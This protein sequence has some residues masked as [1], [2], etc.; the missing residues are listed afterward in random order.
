MLRQLR[1][2][3]GHSWETEDDTAAYCPRCGELADNVSLFDEAPPPPEIPQDRLDVPTRDA[4]GYPVIPGYDLREKLPPGPLGVE[5]YRAR[6]LVAE[7]PVVVEVVVARDDSGQTAWAALRGEA[8][9][10]G[11]LDHPNVAPLLA[12]GERERLLFYNILTDDSGPTLAEWLG[13]KPL[14]WRE[15]VDLGRVLALALQHAHE[16]GVV[17]RAIQPRFIRLCPAE[18]DGPGCVRLRGVWY[19]PRLEK[20]GQARTKVIE[21]EPTDLEAQPEIPAYLSPEQ[22][23]GQARDIGPKTDQFALGLV[24]AELLLG[25][26]PLAGPNRMQTLDNAM[27]SF[28]I[29]EPLRSRVSADLYAVLVKATSYRA[30]D[31]YDSLGELAGDLEDVR[32]GRAPA[33]RPPGLLRLLRGAIPVGLLLAF[34]LGGGLAGVVLLLG[35]LAPDPRFGPSGELAQLR[36]EANHAQFREAEREKA[37]YEQLSRF[38]EPV[39]RARS[40]RLFDAGGG[41]VAHEARNQ[42]QAARGWTRVFLWRRLDG[43]EAQRLTLPPAARPTA[44][45]WEIPERG[46]LVGCTLREAGQVHC[47]QGEPLQ[48]QLIDRFPWPVRALT[49]TGVE[50]ELLILTS[51]SAENRSQLYRLGG[52]PASDLQTPARTGLAVAQSQAGPRVVTTDHKSGTWEAVG[53]LARMQACDHP[54]AYVVAS[55]R[56]P[57]YFVADNAAQT[58]FFTGTGFH[59][60]VALGD[61]PLVTALVRSLSGKWLAAGGSAG[62]VRLWAFEHFPPVP[63]TLALHDRWR[64]GQRPI[65]ALAFLPGEECLAIGTDDGHLVLYDLPTGLELVNT[66]LGDG[67]ITALAF[68]PTGRKLAVIHGER[69]LLWE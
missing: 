60:G 6:Q 36:R 30:G 3:S 1:C 25:K 43:K 22:A 26:P 12:V 16:R 4:R 57:G 63:P 39:T 11:K 61:L 32:V 48:R 18:G 20:F 8:R 24:V 23:L 27:R 17:H 54:T 55:P 52:V 45:N 62:V 35:V 33:A 44:L 5:R 49:W 10:L 14:P 41:E 13:E 51:S 59:L 56:E 9:A 46:L 64:P 69:V 42:M 15:A 19:R 40:Q 31:R 29:L 21:H 28:P 34:L 58:I 37:H 2:L 50:Q 67:A 53:R 65:T 66:H 47:W 7:R 38:A 68:D